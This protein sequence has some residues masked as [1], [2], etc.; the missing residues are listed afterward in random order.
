MSTAPLLIE[1]GCE[2]LPASV[3]PTAAQWLLESL[4]AALGVDGGDQ[5]WLATPRRLIAHFA[6]VP[7]RQPDRYE[8][9]TGPAL[10]VARAADGSWTKAAEGFARGQG[11]AV[12]DLVVQETP[13]G[14]YVAANKHIAGRP[15]A[16]VVAE[17]LPRLLRTM[18][19]P[20]RMRWGRQPE[21][22]GR[23]VHWLVAL[24]GENAI[25][26]TFAGVQS[27]RHVGGHRFYHPTQLLARADLPRHLANLRDAHVL[28]DPAE[29][30]AE[31]ERGIARLAAEVG[32]RWRS[33]PATVQTV[34]YLTEWPQPLLGAFSPEFLEIPPEV[35]FTTLRENQKLLLL[36][37]P[38]GRLL[39]HFVAVANTLADHSRAT[40]A[41]GNARV[42]SA[43]LSD[44]RFF[45]REDT[46]RRLADRVADLDARIWLAGLGTIGDKVRRIQATADALC[47]AACPEHAQNVARAAL[48][49]KADL[50]TKMVFEFPEL[51]GTIGSYYAREDGESEQVATAIA[52]HYQPRFAGDAIAAAAAGQLLAVADKL[53]TIA[54]CFALGLLPTGAQDP[55]SLRRAALGV[56]RTLGESGLVCSLGHAVDSAVAQLPVAVRDKAGEGLRQAILGFLRGRLVAL[57]A[58]RFGVDTTE[59]VVEAGF[60]RVDTVEPRLR[61]LLDL[62]AH[63]DFAASAAAFKR[64]A[65][66]V[67]K[68]A[69]A[70]DLG[71]GF[72]VQLCEKPVEHALHAKVAELQAHSAD[73]IARGDWPAALL[74]LAQVRPAVDSFFDGVLV[75]ADDGAVRR[76]RLALLALVAGLFAPIAEFGRLPG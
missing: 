21:A 40:V 45:Y 31:I 71:A 52:S 37:G 1:I 3:A 12:A 34:V 18:P 33:D 75:M 27:G 72:S 42:V 11:V 44:A 22:F 39:P 54:G 8:T 15:L 14:A 47:A 26:F 38:D 46:K 68:S 29:R 20:K 49:C 9:A 4:A 55:Y 28:A 51:Q 17:A 76:N 48:L 41:A 16:E 50:S 53:D 64:V 63:P 60:D 73:A 30:Q 6:A 59:A 65:N 32:G 2:E 67:R 7:E 23:P 61:A 36:D 57:W 56:L 35:I 66:L 69:D 70:G 13:K 43:R 19:L 62:R 24:H 74:T 10:A 25:E 5:T 58:D